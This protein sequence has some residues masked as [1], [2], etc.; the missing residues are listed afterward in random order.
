ML[1]A[2]CTSPPPPEPVAKVV[3][4]P[5][6][7][8]PPIRSA[9]PLQLRDA[10]AR[11]ASQRGAERPGLEV[12]RSD[13]IAA[14]IAY[15]VD[16]LSRE[17]SGEPLPEHCV[18]AGRLAAPAVDFEMRMP[19]QWNGRFF[20]QGS[21]GLQPRAVEAFGRT[22]G[23]S[24]L[25]NNALS[26][27]YAVLASN[28]GDHRQRV[29]AASAA[30]SAD[31][32]SLH[33][34]AEAART[35][36]QGYYGRPAD[37][38]YFVGCSAGG[39]EGLLFAQRWPETFDGIVAVAPLLRERDATVAAAWT[40]QR[41][42][43][44]APLTRQRKPVLSR[45]F[46]VDEMFVVADAILKQCD[47]LDGVED[48][49]VMDM[50]NCR[51]DP[52]VLRCA[53]RGAKSC[54]PT[55]KVRALAEAMGGPRDAAGEPRYALWAWDPGIAG[56]GWRDWTMGSAGAGEAPNPGLLALGVTI[57]GADATEQRS[58]RPHKRA[59]APRPD[60]PRQESA[61]GT[62]GLWEASLEAFRRRGG[63]LLLVHGAADPVVSAWATV[64]YQQRLDKSAARA[65]PAGE[66]DYVRTFIVPGMN[67][68][69][70]GPST[71]RFDALAPLVEWVEHEQ[72]PQRIEARGS[73]VLRDEARPLCPWPQV[74]RYRGAGSPHES[75]SYEC[76]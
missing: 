9:Q 68:C 42:M 62:D 3:A 63:K 34:T 23:A 75:A 37:R 41:F 73:A 13:L 20:F 4:G 71:D 7:A 1:V 40:L 49:F 66:P 6:P 54:L 29:S 22:T 51:F 14:G 61:G 16:P 74:A 57:P 44:V 18:V 72:A 19:S 56:P 46:S 24:G 53:R 65:E 17:V 52:S 55:A 58:T 76:R 35:L 48:G 10:A 39:R 21:F 70:G 28:A 2:A 30:G 31:D 69:D 36:I 8:A 25:A 12:A 47:A 5:I 45:A 38:S 11:C 33:R 32:D 60:A 67:H 50:A 27:G 59:V 43:A 15:A 64:D 26:Q